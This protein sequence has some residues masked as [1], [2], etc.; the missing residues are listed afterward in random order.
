MKICLKIKN[1]KP[2]QPNGVPHMLTNSIGLINCDTL[3]DEFQ[4]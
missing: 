4:L 2:R 1:P 3:Y